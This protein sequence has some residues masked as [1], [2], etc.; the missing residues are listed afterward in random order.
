L[1][2]SYFILDKLSLG[3]E[4]G[5]GKNGSFY[6][7]FQSV[8]PL[9]YNIINRK[10]SPFAELTFHHFNY[11]YS[12][13]PEYTGVWNELRAG[14]GLSYAG[15]IKNKLGFEISIDYNIIGNNPNIAPQLLLTPRITYTFP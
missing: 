2:G 13:P 5:Y 8:I 14:I 4:I 6:R 11:K 1:R 9:R 12:G 15:A 3:L 7:H 10:L